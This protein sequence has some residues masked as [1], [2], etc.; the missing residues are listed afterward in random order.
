[1]VINSNK[2]IF[3][4]HSSLIVE[5][6]ETKILCDPWFKGSAFN[7]GWRLLFEDSHNI[8]Q[9]K[10]DYIWISHEHP[11]HFSIPTLNEL[12][13]SKQFLYQKTSDRKVKKW[14][15]QK[16]HLVTEL[17]DGKEYDFNDIKLTS[18]ISDGYDSAALFKFS[19]GDTI[20]N[21]NDARIELGDTIQK[22]KIN[23]LDR[24]KII[25]IQYS[26]ANWAGNEMDQ[27]ISFHQQ[28]LVIDR[29]TEIYKAFKPEKI[30]LFASYVFCSHEENFFWNKNFWLAYVAEK[31]CECGI[32]I[33]IPQ[34]NQ[35]IKID[36][37]VRED[38]VEKNRLAIDFWGKKDDE[39]TVK[40]HSKIDITFD[41]IEQSYCKWYENI[42]QN[43]S[44]E[45]ILNSK[46]IDFSLRVKLN[47]KNCVL[48][49]SLLKKSFIRST[50][51]IFDCIVSSETLIFLLKNNFGRGTV[52]I[53][54]R[55][56]FSY[57][58]AHRFFI[59]FF[60]PYANNIGKFFKNEH[61]TSEK[62]QSIKSTSVMMSIL[63]FNK[64]SNKNF[65]KDI[66]LFD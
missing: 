24:L 46:N 31:L 8:N 20:L 37:L 45:M 55:I 3:L 63:K 21:I 41:E 17:E 34:P 58:F 16:H 53:N 15:E 12:T 54:S 64:N 6:E 50:S 23:D 7:N 52:T 42:W 5:S 49:L 40:D 47:D 25:T 13:E 2:L 22:I 18:F 38:F 11:D 1:M 19:N 56:Q 66:Q 39:A 35:I 32:N 44:L 36:D 57:D 26:Y 59:F 14:L 48:E 43:N 29:I 51:E 60:I 65:D 10:Y 28:N 27:D 4:N 9:V 30:L 61:L 33:I 62:L